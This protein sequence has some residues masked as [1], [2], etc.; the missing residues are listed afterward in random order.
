[1][2]LFPLSLDTIPE[3]LIQKQDKAPLFLFQKEIV[4]INNDIQQPKLRIVLYKI[5]IGYIHIYINAWFLITVQVTAM[6]L[7]TTM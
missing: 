4:G 6:A 5:Y 7:H 2:T 3:F 1:M